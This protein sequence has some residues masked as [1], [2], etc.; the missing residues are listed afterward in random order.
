MSCLL[1][2]SGNQAEFGGEIL[3][4]FKGLKN[5]AKPPVW[6]FPKLL[7]CLDCGSSR[8]MTPESELVLLAR[9]SA[10]RRLNSATVSHSGVGLRFEREDRLSFANVL[11]NCFPKI[12]ASTATNGSVPTCAL[13]T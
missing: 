8:F 2:G 10:K 11:T 7:V 4:H 1:C 6:V 9:Y 12:T 3:I 5:L 13:T